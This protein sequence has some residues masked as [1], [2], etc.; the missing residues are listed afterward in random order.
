MRELYPQAGLAVLPSRCDPR[1]S[2]LNW[3][4]VVAK[5]VGVMAGEEKLAVASS[6]PREAA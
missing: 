5:M 1:R 4:T 3:D 6:S 2:V